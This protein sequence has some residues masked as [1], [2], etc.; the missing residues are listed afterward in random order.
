MELYAY[1]CQYKVNEISQDLE[2]A[3]RVMDK[4]LIQLKQF[5]QDE[6]NEKLKSLNSLFKVDFSAFPVILT[7]QRNWLH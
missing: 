4:E 5:E 2:C 6:W 7:E 3:L 1:L